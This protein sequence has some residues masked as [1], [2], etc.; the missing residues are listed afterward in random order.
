MTEKWF[1]L[2]AN[3]QYYPS[4]GTGDWIGV[5]ATYE[6]AV[7]AQKTLPNEIGNF[8]I[9]DLRLYVKGRND[10]DCDDD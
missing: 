3:D 6:E 8:Y 4:S 5:Y 2:I 9:V 1:L 7:E 10:E